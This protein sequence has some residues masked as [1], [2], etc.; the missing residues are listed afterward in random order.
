MMAV[1]TVAPSHSSTTWGTL[2]LLSP[3]FCYFYNSSLTCFELSDC[4][5]QT[6]AMASHPASAV[7]ALA[8]Y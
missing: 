5:R 1:I 6:E 7:L 4:L 3:Y 8:R 2:S